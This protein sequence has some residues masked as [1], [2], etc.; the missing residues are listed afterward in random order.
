MTLKS[1][2]LAA[3]AFELPLNEK[4]HFFK[5]GDTPFELPAVDAFQHGAEMENARLLPL[6]TAMAEVVEAADE[7]IHKPD[8]HL[9][10]ELREKL[11]ALKLLVSHE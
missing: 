9:A 6:L 3:A 5:V 8:G 11:E 2:I 10:I 1:Q 4:P 7:F